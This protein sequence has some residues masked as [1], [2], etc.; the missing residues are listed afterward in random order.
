MRSLRVA[1]A[2]LGIA[3]AGGHRGAVVAVLCVIMLMQS[4]S[5]YS[6]LMISPTSGARP[7]CGPW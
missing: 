5:A 4:N 1:A 6:P 2:H 7:N 3:S